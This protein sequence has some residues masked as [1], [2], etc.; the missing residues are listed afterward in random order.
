MGLKIWPLKLAKH[1]AETTCISLSPAGPAGC[2]PLFALRPIN[3]H[4]VMQGQVFLG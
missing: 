3:N 2:C 1:L 4:L